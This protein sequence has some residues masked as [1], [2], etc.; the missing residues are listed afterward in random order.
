M[1]NKVVPME[2][3]CLNLRMDYPVFMKLVDHLREFLI[4]DLLAFRQDCI[5]PEK[6]VA[7]ALYYLKDQGSLRMTA[8]AFGVAKSTV[9]KSIKTVCTL[10]CDHLGPKLISFPSTVEEMDVVAN[11]F[12]KKFGIPQVIGCVDG[13]HIPIKKPMENPHDYFCYKM[14]Y[15]LNCQA[16]CNEKGIFTNVEVCW[17]GSVHDARIYANCSVNKAFIEKRLP[18]NLKEIVPG[19][20][21]VPPVLLGDP[22]YPLLPNVMKEYSSNCN[23]QEIAFNNRLRSARN[24]IEC[25]FG[26]LKARW[27]ILGRCLDVDLDFAPTLIYS[28]FVLHNYCEISNAEICRDDV[29]RL[30]TI[31]KQTQ[32]CEHHEKMDQLFSYSTGRGK[33]IRE[34]LKEYVFDQFQE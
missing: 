11:N 30:I 20:A 23:R 22:V 27:R 25:A 26:R 6:R 2:E 31:E 29:Q 17:P 18:R 5:S 32:C 12:E 7:I 13:T 28:C 34:A 19:H 15:S 24:Q 8:N 21:L 1:V 9:S 10:L 14:K 4:C 3:W 33:Q 16:I